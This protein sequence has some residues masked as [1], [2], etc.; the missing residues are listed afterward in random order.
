M[1]RV[2]EMINGF[3]NTRGF[4]AREAANLAEILRPHGYHTMAELKDL[5]GEQPDK[6]AELERL[7]WQEA[8]RFGVLIADGGRF[9]GWSVFIH[10]NRVHYTTNSFGERS[11]ATSTLAIP[12]GRASLRAD[13][14]RVDRDEGLVRFYINDLAA[15]EGRLVPFRWGNFVNEPLEVSFDSQTPVDEIYQS[16][17][18]FAGKIIDVTID[19]VGHEVVDPGLLLEELM[20]S[21]Q[22]FKR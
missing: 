1:G 5:A 6:L 2:A 13:A 22:V 21:Q 19:V 18:R 3:P 9:G 11:R 20:R 10:G 15:G 12:A 4:A 8:E 14:V 16:P 17:F 7:W